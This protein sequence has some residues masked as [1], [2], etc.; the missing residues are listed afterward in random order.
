MMKPESTKKKST[1]NFPIL[2]INAKTGI[3]RL[4]KCAKEG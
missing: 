4:L 2:A 1:P 3:S